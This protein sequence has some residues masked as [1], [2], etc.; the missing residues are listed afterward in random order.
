MIPVQQSNFNNNPNP[1]PMKAAITLLLAL[2][3]TFTSSANF[4]DLWFHNDVP[5][6]VE[7]FIVFKDGTGDKGTSKILTRNDSCLALED[8]QGTVVG[9]YY[10]FLGSNTDITY[11]GPDREDW[12]MKPISGR[13]G[14]DPRNYHGYGSAYFTPIYFTP[15]DT[16]V[17]IRIT[18]I[19]QCLGDCY[20]GQGLYK[21]YKQWYNGQWKNAQ[22]T[23]EGEFFI[24]DTSY[25]GPFLDGQFNGDFEIN[26][27]GYMEIGK[28]AYNV[29]QGAFTGDMPY[30]THVTLAYV[31]GILHG[32][33]FMTW[34][35]KGNGTKQTAITFEQGVAGVYHGTPSKRNKKRTRDCREK[36]K[37]AER[38]SFSMFKL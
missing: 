6:D 30:K 26:T 16:L 12:F 29:R 17:N 7:V 25:V 13:V 33:A 36:A 38:H 3:I 5:E 27:D 11:N 8:H 28:Y 2:V 35:E 10:R 24:N 1:T 4:V 19:S 31:D 37:E 32:D 18:E 23:G 20:N 34:V 21:G 9:Y 15:G 14:C 22:P